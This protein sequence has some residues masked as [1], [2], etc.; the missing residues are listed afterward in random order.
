M[1]MC[2]VGEPSL[3]TFE[4]GRVIPPQ[5]F[6]ALTGRQQQTFP[7]RAGKGATDSRKPKVAPVSLDRTRMPAIGSRPHDAR[8]QRRP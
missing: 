6:D 2:A 5:R 4:N 1:R 8:L 7:P 3:A